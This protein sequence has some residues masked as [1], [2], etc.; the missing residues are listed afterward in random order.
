LFGRGKGNYGLR[1]KALNAVQRV[2]QLNPGER[3][4]LRGLWNPD[5]A[6]PE[7]DDLT[8]FHDDS[9]FKNLLEK[10]NDKQKPPTES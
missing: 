1:K 9:D 8:V 10:V 5:E 3:T 6:S 7:E 2:L 4:S